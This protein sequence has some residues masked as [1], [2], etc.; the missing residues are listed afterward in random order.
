MEKAKTEHGVDREDLL[1]QLL[2]GIPLISLIG[3]AM[4]SQSG[5][6]E[7]HKDDGDVSTFVVSVTRG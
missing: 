6:D 5:K 2:A 7:G 3:L 4:R 1:Q